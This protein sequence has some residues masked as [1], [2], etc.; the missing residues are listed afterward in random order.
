VVAKPRYLLSFGCIFLKQWEDLI[1]MFTGTEE[2]YQ[3][4]TISTFPLKNT[5]NTLL[6]IRC[7]CFWYSSNWTQVVVL[8][9]QFQFLNFPCFIDLCDIYIMNLFNYMKDMFF[10]VLFI[11]GCTFTREG[12]IIKTNSS[13]QLGKICSTLGLHNL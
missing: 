4:A 2:K 6:V 1:M 11:C 8:P 5:Y 7:G 9:S 3:I 10:W 13:P 12:H